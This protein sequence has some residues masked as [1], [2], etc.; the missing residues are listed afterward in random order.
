MKPPI[1]LADVKPD[2]DL[3]PIDFAWQAFQRGYQYAC[4]KGSGDDIGHLHDEFI[5]WWNAHPQTK[6]RR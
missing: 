6:V 5:S 1:I 4:G 2:A 3:R